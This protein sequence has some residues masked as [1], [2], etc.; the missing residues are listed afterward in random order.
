MPFSIEKL[1]SRRDL[2]RWVPVVSLPAWLG[3]TRARAAQTPAAAGAG[4]KISPDI[5]QSIGVRPFI[6]CRG[7]LTIVGGSLELPEVRAAKEAAAHHFVQLDELMDAVG[8]RLAELTGAEWGMVSAGCAAAIT[9]A[10]SACVAGDNPDLHVRMPNLGGFRKDEVIIAKHSRNVYDAAIRAAGVRVIEVNSVPD[11]EAAIGPRTAMIYIFAG[12]AAD[13]VAPKYEDITRIAKERNVPVMVD[14]AAEGLTIPNVHLKRGATLVGYSGGKALCGPQCAGIL[15]GRK[16]L[17]KAAWVHSAP[18]HGYARAMKVGKEEIIGMLAAV[19]AWVK[20]DHEG[21]YRQW[22]SWMEQIGKRVSQ[23]PGVAYTV[24]EPQGLSNHTPGVSIRWD[25]AKLGIT[26][27]RVSEIVYT[28]EPRIALNAAGGGRRQGG[29][30][31]ETGVS[32]SAWMMQLN[33]VKI[34]ADRLYQVLSKPPA[35]KPAQQMPAAA[36]LTGSW[37]VHIEYLAGESDHMLFLEQQ[38]ER[39][40]GSHRGDFIARD[41]TGR[42]NGDDVV[43]RSSL[44]ERAMGDSLNFTFSGKISGNTMSGELDMGEYRK[45]RWSAQRHAYPGQQ[46]ATVGGKPA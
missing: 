10:T 3:G 1:F 23:V 19:E 28:T 41:L 33:E 35:Q 38:G 2:F 8:K 17:V 39:I 42:V 27:E 5:Y 46:P 9:H 44:T 43:L 31:N 34:V 20:R 30:P 45:A 21:E 16:D 4:L 37:E 11:L 13:T 14:A 7:T 15:I 24:R 26:G 22:M 40:Q 36:N 18:H 25:A 29:E 32:I 6:N 12:P